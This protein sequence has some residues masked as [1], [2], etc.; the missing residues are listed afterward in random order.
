MHDFF[1]VPIGPDPTLSTRAAWNFEFSV[2]IAGG[3][4]NVLALDSLI[5]TID[6][7]TPSK[8]R[9]VILVSDNFGQQL[10]HLETAEFSTC[11]L[12]LGEE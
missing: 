3:L 9:K 2:G 1:Q 8:Q 5:L 12:I 4:L 11:S 7:L 10:L 6:P